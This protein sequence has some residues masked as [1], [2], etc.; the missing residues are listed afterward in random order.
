MDD[1]V[2]I[3]L[4]LAGFNNLERL[5]VHALATVDDPGLSFP[6][7]GYSWSLPAI[8]RCFE[9]ASS[10]KHITLHFH[11]NIHGLA[12]LPE[13][14]WSPLDFYSP[15]P[16]LRHIDLQVSP[17]AIPLTTNLTSLSRN[18]HLKG[19]VERGLLTIEHYIDT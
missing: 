15:S 13:L 18:R 2:I 16:M 9:S 6:Y 10:L 19:L 12:L 7:A 4:H 14:D 1:R 3:P 11:I 8:V 17:T 5:T